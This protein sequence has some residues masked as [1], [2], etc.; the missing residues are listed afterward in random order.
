[1]IKTEEKKVVLKA[2]DELGRRVTAADVAAKTGLPIL[3]VAPELNKVAA[4]ANGHMEVSKVGD[5]A[6]SFKP[7][8]Q[9]AYAATGFKK[10]LQ[11]IGKKIF[12]IGFM[13]LRMSFGVMLILSFIA[14]IVL[15]FVA[16]LA[17][18]KG[19]DSDSGGGDGFNFDFFDYMI[20]RD[21][22][23]W[24]T[25]PSYSNY[26]TY[27]DYSRPAT[28]R[29]PKT[30]FLHNCFSFLFG[31][32]D[33]NAHL[34]ERKWQ[35]VAQVIRKNG[36]VVTAE[37]I[38]PYSGF[39]PKNEDGM[40]PV[41]VRFDGKPEV[42]EDGNILYTFPSLQVSTSALE[43]HQSTPAFL[44]EFPRQFTA[45]D[46]GDLIPVYLLAGFNF[47]GSW[48]LLAQSAH[49]P[50]L[51]PA[52]FLIV[53]LFWYGTFFVGVPLFRWVGLQYLNAR[54][55]ARNDVRKAASELVLRPQPELKTKLAQAADHRINRK[56]ISQKDI[57]YTTEKDSLD[58]KD[59][60]DDKFEKLALEQNEFEPPRS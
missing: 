18:N 50:A 2:I 31:D 27:I 7:G 5:I 14:V 51:A 3:V 59:E 22:F 40:L 32:G 43:M 57:V 54:I 25:V 47:L 42:T 46:Q 55:E 23:Y 1:M 60:L 41:L 6:Y 11:Q 37:Q 35:L 8:F 30:N 10:Q 33:P 12:D 20:L 13:I 24:G 48:W 53:L 19:S 52:H 16:V 17:M 9:N 36:G 29:P 26:P 56:Q 45:A 58:Q 38:A 21:L 39:D 15:I 34:E 28:T 49:S 4:E 44:R